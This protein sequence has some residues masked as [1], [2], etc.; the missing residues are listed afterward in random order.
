MLEGRRAG[1]GAPT[2]DVDARRVGTG[3]GALFT[4]LDADDRLVATAGGGDTGTG[5]VDIGAGDACTA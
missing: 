3:T 2:F 1:V 5:P 4:W